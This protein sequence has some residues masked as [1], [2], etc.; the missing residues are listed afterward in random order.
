MEI[1]IQAELEQELQGLKEL[2]VKI[3]QFDEQKGE[4]VT[5]LFRKQ[6]IVQF[7]QVKLVAGKAKED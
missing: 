4:L 6:G 7:L 2:E 3:Q 5:Q 1:D